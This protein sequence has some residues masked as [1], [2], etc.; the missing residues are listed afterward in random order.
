MRKYLL[1]PLLLVSLAVSAQK[2]LVILHTNDTHSCVLPMSENLADTAV[3]GRGGF[4]RRV[5]MVNEERAVHPTLLY[6]DS[7][8][9]SQGS[10]YYTLYKGEVETGLMSRMHCDAATLGNHE[11]DSGMEQLVKNVREAPFPHVCAN[12]DFTGTPLEGLVKPFV[13]I[14]RD[15][16]RI[17]VFG[18]APKL[19]G[20]VEQK[21]F[22]ATRYLDPVSVAL[23]TA[24]RLRQVEHCDVVICI[25]HLGWS[26][27]G[28]IAMIKGSRFIDLVL[29]GHTHTAFRDLRFVPNLDGQQVPVD[30]NGKG[31]TRVSRITL[32]LSEIQPGE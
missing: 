12:Y 23:A 21:N 24:T 14:E 10:A 18:L 2:Q 7:G 15:S 13:V 32:T 31:G 20:L 19:D 26:P 11:W 5:T 29:G 8:D 3:A 22:L 6:F 4:L 17:G 28:D 30:Q 27:D 25:S 1:L 9:Y 16:L